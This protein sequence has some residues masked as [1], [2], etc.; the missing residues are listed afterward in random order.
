M[1]A[2]E[3]PAAPGQAAPEFEPRAAL[4][5]L[6]E[7]IGLGVADGGGEIVFLGE[8]PILPSRLRLGAAIAVPIMAC[9]VGAATAWRL[10]GGEGQDLAIDLRE[11]I[12]GIT[13]HLAWHPTINGLPH[14][15][16]LALENF[17]TL[18]PYRTR[19]GRT[20]MASGV[21]PHMVSSWLRFLDCPPDWEKIVER[22]ERWDAHELEQTANGQGLPVTIARTVEEWQSHPQGALLARAPVIQVEKI[23]DSPPRPLLP[24]AQPLSDVRVLSFTHAVAGPTVGRTLAEHGADVLNATFPN[25]F[26]HDF[27][28][29]EANV[30]SRSANLDLRIP[31]HAAR[32]ERLLAGADVVVDNHRP[33]TM[34]TH[35]LGAEQLA[36]RHPG[37]VSVSV[38]AYGHEGP[39]STRAG[40]DMN[41]S[42]A[43]GVMATEGTQD[44]PKLPPTGLL[45]DFITGYMGAAGTIAALIRRAKEGGS[46][47]VIVSLTRTG[48]FV[49]SLGQVDPALAGRGR[50]NELRAP[51]SVSAET[52][53][54]TLEQ[55]ASPVRFGATMPRWTDP[56]LVPRGSS[57]AEWRPM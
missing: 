48:M 4:A 16:A 8:D 42:A 28:Y 52:P 57:R 23:G 17:F 38:S 9:A 47:R 7:P 30:G 34:A 46:Y 19:D 44:D 6:L 27:I 45:N 50:A 15:H 37:V 1:A 35:G 20:V 49:T 36:E 22:F 5:T 56:I 51:P 12:H 32:I 14:G 33:G 13:P 24:A 54:G 40:F 10:R 55:L 25:H 41:G 2:T 29:N 39:W 3:R 21:Y 26:E 11:A 53:L 18:A 43:S 31:E